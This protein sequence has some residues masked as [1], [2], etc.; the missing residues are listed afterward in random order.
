[1][2]VCS[3]CGDVVLYC[4]CM[5]ENSYELSQLTS[6][7]SFW[8]KR[9]DQLAIWESE[10]RYLYG[11]PT[12]LS[13]IRSH[14]HGKYVEVLI[15]GFCLWMTE[16]DPNAVFHVAKDMLKGCRFSNSAPDWSE[17]TRTD[18]VY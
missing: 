10:T 16:R 7:P 1:M 17:M 15:P 13:D 2:R 18:V 8:I 3:I 14:L 11:N 12:L 4:K 5:Y 9:G 6:N